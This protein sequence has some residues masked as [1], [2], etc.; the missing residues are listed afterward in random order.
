[1]TMPCVR[2]GSIEITHHPVVVGAEPVEVTFVVAFAAPEAWGLLVPPDG[3]P[4]KLD[5][6]VAPPPCDW[7]ATYAFPPDAPAGLW[8][9]QVTDDT[10]SVV[11]E[12]RVEREGTK[13]RTRFASFELR[14][15]EAEAGEPL[16]LRG[17]VEIESGGDWAPLAGQIVTIGFHGADT[18][19]RHLVT[20]T[21]T[22]DDGTFGALA[23]APEED[24]DWR[25][26]LDGGP[27]F[28]GSRSPTFL[29]RS[30]PATEIVK[31]TIRPYPNDRLKHSG[32]LRTKNGRTRLD[33]LAVTVSKGGV[34][35]TDHST[36]NP[37]GRFTV[38]TPRSN[39]QW[40]AS[41]AAS[42]GYGSSHATQDYP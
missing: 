9:V 30:L 34:S 16:V 29:T 20:Q 11:R 12:F 2:S 35:V 15:H 31:Y 13:A 4:V 37:S 41:F 17:R 42:G 5:L 21:L 1:M 38:I 3:P 32:V 22:G 40:R 24:G 27:A 39:G 10:A 7:R 33:D 14:P 26:E 28:M 25:A 23:T 8:R 19:G 6:T 18:C 36:G